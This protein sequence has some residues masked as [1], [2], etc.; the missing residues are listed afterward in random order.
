MTVFALLDGLVIMDFSQ[1]VI[2]KDMRCLAIFVVFVD[3]TH[4]MMDGGGVNG[5]EETHG[6]GEF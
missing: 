6:L 1:C 3:L 4:V 5:F 2:L